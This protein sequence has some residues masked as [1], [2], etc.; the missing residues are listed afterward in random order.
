LLRALFSKPRCLLFNF[1]SA[2]HGHYE[3]TAESAGRSFAKRSLR[4][5]GSAKVGIA[6]I[7]DVGEEQ[8]IHPQKKGQW[9]DASR[10]GSIHR[11]RREV[12]YSG[13]SY[14]SM[15]IDGDR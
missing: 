2:V 6:V 7:T 8:D 14:K 3:P 9:V 12:V 4:D 11:L 10:C 15:K 13:P 1:L 5:Q